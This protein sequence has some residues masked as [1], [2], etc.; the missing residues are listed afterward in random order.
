MPDFNRIWLAAG[1]SNIGDGV[2]LG[3]VPVLLASD[4]TNNPILISSTIGVTVASRVIASLPAGV[5]VD[6]H[7]RKRVFIRVSVFRGIVV[8][9]IGLL[10]WAGHL[11]IPL[12]WLLLAALSAGEAFADAASVAMLPEVVEDHQLARANSRLISTLTLTNDMI[13]ISIGPWLFV[14]AAGAPFLIDSASFLVAAFLLLSVRTRPQHQVREVVELEVGET[15]PSTYSQYRDDIVEC[16]RFLKGHPTAR[17]FVLTA[18]PSILASGALV[19]TF[20]LYARD[21][22][23]LKEQYYGLLLLFMAIG[24]VAGSFAAE[25]SMAR[26]KDVR[27]ILATVLIFEGFSDLTMGVSHSIPL[28]F[29]VNIVGGFC[30]GIFIVAGATVRQQLT[31]KELQGR[32]Q[33][34]YALLG[35]AS[36]PLGTVLG[37]VMVSLFDVRTPLLFSAATLILCG[38]AVAHVTN[39][40]RLATLTD[41]S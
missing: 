31:P 10:A 24:L 27:W 1:I 14:T 38:L 41:V 23:H 3:A 16:I 34:T 2:I 8:G 20:V 5:W 36:L 25:R 6:R 33:S 28:V 9:V 4:L 21:W 37:G 26:V 7:P 12:L 22:L 40:S 30:V 39:T 13:G 18:F 11:T 15:K 17:A 29:G 19:G 32:M 35:Q